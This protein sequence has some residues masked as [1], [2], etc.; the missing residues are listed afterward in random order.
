MLEKVNRL[1]DLKKRT[2]PTGGL[3][4]ERVSFYALMLI[5]LR[6]RLK[7]RS[8]PVFIGYNSS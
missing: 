6:L 2:I 5:F 4:L 1:Q 7:N 3:F 8:L